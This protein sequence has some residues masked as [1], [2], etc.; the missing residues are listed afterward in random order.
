MRK[1]DECF[2]YHSVTE[3][4]IKG[5]VRVIKV[6]YPDNTDKKGIFGIVDVTYVKNLNE[7]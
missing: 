7:V 5:I 2:F 3:K 1:G 6:Y 4:A